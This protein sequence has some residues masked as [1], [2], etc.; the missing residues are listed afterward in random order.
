[1][2]IS[3][4]F[5]ITMDAIIKSSKL[6]VAQSL[7]AR[8][9]IEFILAMIWWNI[10]SKNKQKDLDAI[11]NTHKSQMKYVWIRGFVY[12]IK[13][14]IAWYGVIRFPLGDAYCIIIQNSLITAI[15]ARIFLKENLPKMVPIV[16]VFGVIGVI[17]VVQPSF[18][19]S[20]LTSETEETKTTETTNID[21]L[22]MILIATILWSIEAL[23][24]RKA[25]DIHVTQSDMVG[26]INMIV[27][28]IPTSLLLNHFVIKDH[29]MGDFHLNSWLF[30]LESIII[31][32]SV[33]V[34]SFLGLSLDILAYQYGDATKVSW[35][36]YFAIAISY[37]YQIF[38]FQQIPTPLQIIG[39]VLVIISC[40]ISLSE[41]F[42]DYTKT[43]TMEEDVDE[44]PTLP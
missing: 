17:L 19:L 29:E 39:V 1:M 16:A 43:K 44:L 2:I 20:I 36:Q 34:L 38:L 31:M 22:T 30:D 26:C 37:M 3:Q 6:K 4:V 40:I 18:L 28:A 10:H 23:M 35:M 12:S 15:L 24:N 33:G 14:T 7:A 13:I 41:A 42:Y 21:G 8:Y 11:D 27:A 9:C 32:L 5:F 25:K